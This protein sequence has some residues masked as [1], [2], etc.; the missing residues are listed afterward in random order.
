MK[1]LYNMRDIIGLRI[2]GLKTYKTLIKHIESG[3][4]NATP[5]GASKY[6]QYIITKESLLSFLGMSETQFNRNF[7]QK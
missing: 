4:L 1:P 3:S 6:R 7:N 2:Q 5:R